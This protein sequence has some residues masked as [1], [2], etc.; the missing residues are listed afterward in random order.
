MT[1]EKFTSEAQTLKKFF[2]LNCIDKHTKQTHHCKQLVYNKET[3]NIELELCSECIKLIHYSFDRLSQC[4]HNPKPRCRTCPDP[5]YSKDE[6]KKVAKLMR[7]SGIQLGIL[8][9]KNF[10]LK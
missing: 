7:Y 5:C 4:P 6:W 8:K 3:I 1:T 10:F 9:I 2:E